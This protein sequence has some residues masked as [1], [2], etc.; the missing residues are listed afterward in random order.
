MSQ[1]YLDL[2]LLK[3]EGKNESPAIMRY[4]NGLWLPKCNKNF[5]WVCVNFAATLANDEHFEVSRVACIRIQTTG[6]TS[7]QPRSILSANLESRAC[8]YLHD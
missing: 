5:G 2:S 6:P 4:L 1:D 7:F 8:H 3:E